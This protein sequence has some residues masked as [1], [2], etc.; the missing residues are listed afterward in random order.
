MAERLSSPSPPQ[1]RDNF[2]AGETEQPRNFPGPQTF[3]GEIF[4]D[5]DDV[6]AVDPARPGGFVSSV[7]YPSQGFVNLRRRRVWVLL[8]RIRRARASQTWCEILRFLIRGTDKTDRTRKNRGVPVARF[9]SFVPR[10]FFAEAIESFH[11]EVRS[12]GLT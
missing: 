2:G 6:G 4:D 7:S 9:Y 11:G 5:G 12:L 10:E 8:A 3:V 1:D